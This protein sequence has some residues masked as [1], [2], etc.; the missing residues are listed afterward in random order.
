MS[1]SERLTS[2]TLTKSL[3]VRKEAIIRIFTG[4]GAR[5]TLGQNFPMFYR[6]IELSIAESSERLS[7]FVSSR[8]APL[9]R[10]PS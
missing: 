6:S 2:E 8:T 3:Q 1:P 4:E 10:S 9:A 5:A 7:S